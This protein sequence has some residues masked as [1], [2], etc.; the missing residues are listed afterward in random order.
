MFKDNFYYI[1]KDRLKYTQDYL[2][3]LRTYI[4][5]LKFRDKVEKEFYKNKI[6]LYLL[7]GLI[8][9]PSDILRQVRYFQTLL[10]YGKA[11]K[12]IQV[13]KEELNKYDQ[14]KFIK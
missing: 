10:Y 1:L 3:D 8:N 4:K 2:I 6:S 13:I 12:E 14:N 7:I 9:L 11:Q 5:A